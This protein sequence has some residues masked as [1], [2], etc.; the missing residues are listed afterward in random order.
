VTGLLIGYA[1]VSTRLS[2]DTEH[3]ERALRE[4]GIP[5]DRIFIDQGFTGTNTRRP[6]LTRAMASLRP[7]DVLVVTKLDRLA[8]SIVDAHRLAQQITERGA[9]L[10]F[11]GT[12]LDLGDPVGKLLF[13]MLA[14]IAEFERD[15]IS[16]RTREGLVTAKLRGRLTG[17]PPK[18][19]PDRERLLVKMV[20][21]DRHTRAEVA[22]IF[23]VG[24]STVSR[25]LARAGQR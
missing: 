5:Q 21:E 13:S 16:M 23:G 1:R 19:S 6:G 3:Q 22:D 24:R 9:S 17:R 2:Q 10:R 8:R 11:N 7:G 12:T 14:M 20:T 25:A 18:L 15:L 4:L